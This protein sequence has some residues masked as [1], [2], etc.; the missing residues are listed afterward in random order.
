MR[1]LNE[2]NKVTMQK[3]SSRQ[4]YTF[5][6]GQYI[7]I[8]LNNISDESQM[9]IE[10]RKYYV[11]NYDFTML[12]YLIDE[13]EFEV[14]PAIARVLQVFEI[15][16]S[17][18]KKKKNQF[19]KNPDEFINDFLFVAG[20]TTLVDVIDYTANMSLV[21]TENIS[22]YDVYINND[23]YGSDVNLIQITTN[24]TLRIQAFK[25]DYSMDAKIIFDSKLYGSSSPF[26]QSNSS[27]SQTYT[28]GVQSGAT[29]NISTGL[30]F[31][32]GDTI[33]LVHNEKNNQNSKIVSYSPETGVLV[34]SGAT[35]V[36]GSG[37]YNSWDIY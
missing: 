28:L 37:T 15:D 34:F 24:D 17:T 27:A 4:A 12:G 35:N 32:S 25:N 3:F 23:Y 6:K 13:A 11:Q 31:L 5:I 19:P 2:L 33:R 10:N 21:G 16:T 20:N 8:I 26:T 9:Q 7:P 22:S 14:K 1:E 36:V 18:L 30:N 29:F